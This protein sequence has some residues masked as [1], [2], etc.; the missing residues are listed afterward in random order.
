MAMSHHQRL[1][2]EQAKEPLL[3]VVEACTKGLGGFGDA[4]HRSAPLRHALGQ[5]LQPID[6]RNSPTR[7]NRT[8]YS[9]YRF[10]PESS[11]QA[12][13]LYLRFTLSL[14][15]VEDLLA[16]RGIWLCQSCSKL[17][18]SDE[19]RYTV[20]LLHH[21]KSAAVQRAL[22]AAA[23]GRPLGALTGSSDPDDADEQ[24]LRGLNL[25]SS[26][27]VDAVC[28]RLRTVSRA[29]AA[30]F[31]NARGR[32]RVLCRSRFGLRAASLPI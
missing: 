25:P 15:D 19:N 14:R 5:R 11:S 29:D 6:R 1:P 27:A 26:D 8:S 18:D 13:W 12:I 24:F 23:S 7:M 20:A 22:D 32:P 10:P 28:A 17:I 3:R 4:Q 21:W 9:G 16:E 30:A 2:A 31:R